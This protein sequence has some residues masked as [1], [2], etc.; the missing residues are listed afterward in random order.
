[1]DEL[2]PC[3]ID[4]LENLLNEIV[5]A[6]LDQSKLMARASD[7][8]CALEDLRR[9]VPG[10][11]H[12]MTVAQNEAYKWAI[13]QNYPSVAARY[14]KILAEA[15]EQLQADYDEINDFEH[16]QCAKLLAERDDLLR[17]LAKINDLAVGYEEDGPF[18]D[19]K[20]AF[21]RVAEIYKL[22]L[23]EKEKGRP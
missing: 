11:K 8:R 18:D 17:R 19:P 21:D 6:R 5:L 16:S 10:N 15:I 3:N 7:L 22:S 2:K 13:D 1:M 9:T 4:R 23:I 14:A 20:E 12:P